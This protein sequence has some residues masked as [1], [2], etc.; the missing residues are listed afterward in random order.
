MLSEKTESFK[1]LRCFY[2]QLNEKEKLI[3]E[4]TE[5]N[6]LLR[7]Y[8]EY[9]EELTEV[10]SKLSSIKK[11]QSTKK[12]NS[13]IML[14]TENIN[15]RNDISFVDKIILSLNLSS[16]LDNEMIRDV[17]LQNLFNSNNDENFKFQFSIIGFT[18]YSMINRFDMG[19]NVKV[20]PT[21]IFEKYKELFKDIFDIEIHKDIEFIFKER[22]TIADYLI[23]VFPLMELVPSEFYIDYKFSKDICDKNYNIMYNEYYK[24][25][26]FVEYLSVNFNYEL[27]I[28]KFIL[29]R[30]N[31][32]YPSNRS[33][34][35]KVS[36]YCRQLKEFYN[37]IDNKEDYKIYK[38]YIDLFSIETENELIELIEVD[39]NIF[40]NTLDNIVNKKDNYISELYFMLEKI[41]PKI[42]SN[43]ISNEMKYLRKLMVEKSL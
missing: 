40:K 2:N 35:S 34:V 23:N 16:Y 5:F 24:I 43:D 3:N 13:D 39:Y 21:F 41:K 33:L 9:F 37:I 25:L 31:Y 4:Y 19:K 6:I 17:I 7:L 14:L 18:F 8:R 11:F 32:L 22:L 15:K 42:S 20:D 26:S 30:D 1:M 27:P 38:N 10:N 36:Y 29:I 28:E 12:I